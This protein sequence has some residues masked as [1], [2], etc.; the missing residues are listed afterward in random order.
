MRCRPTVEGKSRYLLAQ[1]EGGDTAFLQW[2]A[3]GDAANQPGLSALVAGAGFA[4]FAEAVSV[5]QSLRVK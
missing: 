2:L 1:F 3:I 4:A 5:P